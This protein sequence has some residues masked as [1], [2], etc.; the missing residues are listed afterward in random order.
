MVAKALDLVVDY[1]MRQFIIELKLWHGMK[2]I[3]Y[4][5]KRI[6]DV[7]YRAAGT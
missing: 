5:G 6:F 4:N 1:G 3:S 2:W 7:K